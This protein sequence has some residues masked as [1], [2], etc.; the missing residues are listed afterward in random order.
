MI[1]FLPGLLQELSLN[2]KYTC[3]YIETHAKVSFIANTFTLI[4]I[5]QEHSSPPM[6]FYI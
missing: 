3:M 2:S 5:S 1:V 6:Y 4:R